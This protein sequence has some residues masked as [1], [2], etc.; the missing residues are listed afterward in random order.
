MSVKKMLSVLGVGS[1]VALLGLAVA[2]RHSSRVTRSGEPRLGSG[3]HPRG[4]LA[5]GGADL[6][7]APVLLTSEFWDAAPESYSLMEEQS[8]P[9]ASLE[10]Y[11]S[12]DTE[13][14]TAE[15]LARATQAPAIDDLSAFDDLNDP[16]EIPADSLSMISDAS[17]R[18][19]AFDLDDEPEPR[20][21]YDPSGHDTPKS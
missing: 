18:A 4:A 2:R 1:A 13:D 14:L 10:P 7:V 21:D 3:V 6:A 17:R 11:D 19:A 5:D 15:W 20:S 16:A 12:L 8:L 9:P